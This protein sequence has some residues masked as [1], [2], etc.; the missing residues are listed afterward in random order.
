MRSL[1]FQIVLYALALA[2]I[3]TC[4]GMQPKKDI[5]KDVTF[6]SSVIKTEKGYYKHIR[7]ELPSDSYVGYIE[8]EPKDSDPTCWRII[9][10][11][12]YSEYRNNG[13]GHNLLQ[14]CIHDIQEQKARKLSWAVIPW[15]PYP[16][17]TEELLDVYKRMLGKID[18][19][20]LA[21]TT[22]KARENGLSP[23]MTL[24]LQ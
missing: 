21:K 1:P 7:A 11:I 18:N 13:I 2:S 4:W 16:L 12:V 24:N 22:V 15:G 5:L 9:R 8:Y 6:I 14:R 20:F 19:S 3:N 17:S 23:K 10:T